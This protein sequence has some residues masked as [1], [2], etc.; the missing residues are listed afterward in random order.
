MKTLLLGSNMH[1]MTQTLRGGNGPHLPHGLSVVNMYTKV[2]TGSKQV[3][4]VVKNLMAILITIAKGI[5]VTQVVAK[6]IV[7]PV[8]LT[9]RT[10]ERLGK[11]QGRQQMRMSVEWRKETLFQQLDL[12]GLEGWFE[13]N[14]AAA[15][16]LVAEYHDIF[17]PWTRW[18]GLYRLGEAWDQGHW[19]WTLQREVPK[20]PPSN[21]GWSPYPHEGNAGSSAIHPSQSP[22]CNAVVSVCKKDRG[23]CF[24][25][26]SIRWMPGPRRILIH[27]PTSKKPMKA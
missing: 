15:Q 14:Q 27:C 23:L 16:A 10:L 21:G 11:I 12:S 9:P 2:T 17:F 26:T 18:A 6:N 4:V 5:K 13:G 7:P 24:V 22:W 3:A 20:D 19:W 25:L 1:V 8:K